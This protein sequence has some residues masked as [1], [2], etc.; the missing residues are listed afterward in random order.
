M[1]TCV[2]EEGRLGGVAHYPRRVLIALIRGYQIALSP[3]LAP[4]C[5]FEPTCS[6]YAAEAIA[7][8]GALRGGRLALARI[9]R[10][11]PFGGFGYDPVP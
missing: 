6:A 7:R 8:H 10:C 2:R 3:H 4:A 5:R 1:S 11:H 9:G